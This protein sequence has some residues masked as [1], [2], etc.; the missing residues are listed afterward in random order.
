MHTL[1]EA[2]IPRLGEIFR[3]DGLSWKHISQPGMRA[4]IIMNHML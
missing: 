4:D 1:S 3:T 2:L